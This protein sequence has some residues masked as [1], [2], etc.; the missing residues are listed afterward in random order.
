MVLSASIGAL[1]ALG[2]AGLGLISANHMSGKAYQRAI[3]LMQEQARLNYKY[4]QKSAEN[5]PTWNRQGLETAGYNP[6]LA[7]QN[8]T[9]GANSSWAS[10][11]GY[12]QDQ[13]TDA[14]TNGV[15]NGTEMAQLAINQQQTDSNVK[16]NEA[17]SRKS[18]SEAINNEIHSKYLD[19]REE[20]ELGQIGAETDK[21]IRETSYYDQLAEN[22]EAERRLQEMGIN[23]NA[24]NVRYQADKAFNASTYASNVNE[25]NNK[26]NNRTNTTLEH[27]RHPY[28]SFG[29]KVYTSGKGDNSQYYRNNSSIYRNAGW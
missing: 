8:A 27:I 1:G 14:I 4:A 13:A 3:G 2:S 9:S 5:S 11:Q 21:L 29:H 26:R 20:N 6:M 12:Q 28:S 15:R 25:R 24:G 18:I 7:V 19:K 22:M 16:L 17:Q 23:V 10:P